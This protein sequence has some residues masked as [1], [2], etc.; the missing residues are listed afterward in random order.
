MM[1]RAKPVDFTKFLEVANQ[2]E[3]YWGALNQLPH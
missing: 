3:L 1:N 2:T